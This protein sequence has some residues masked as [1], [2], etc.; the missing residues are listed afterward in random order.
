MIGAGMGMEDALIL[1]TVL[2]AISSSSEV[3]HALSVYEKMSLP[4]RSRVAELSHEGGLFLTGNSDMG[5]Y[6]M[7]FSSNF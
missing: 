5:L 6:V 7:L 1:E 4:R 2:G 3:A